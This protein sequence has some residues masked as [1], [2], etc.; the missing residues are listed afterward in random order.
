MIV[1]RTVNVQVTHGKMISE[2]HEGTHKEHRMLRKTKRT[3]RTRSKCTENIGGNPSETYPEMRRVA[4]RVKV[5]IRAKCMA[6]ARAC[7]GNDKRG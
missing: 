1:E 2:M 4:Y 7:T 3:K 6:N 5:C